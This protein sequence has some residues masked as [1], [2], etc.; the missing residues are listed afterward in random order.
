[1]RLMR[2]CLPGIRYDGVKQFLTCC[3]V[4]S[5]HQKLPVSFRATSDRC[6]FTTITRIPASP[7]DDAIVHIDDIDAN[8]TQ[9]SL[10]MT[11]FH[12]DEGFRPLFP[13]VLDCLTQTSRTLSFPVISNRFVLAKRCVSAQKFLIR[14]P[15]KRSRR[16]SFTSGSGRQR[17]ATGTRAERLSSY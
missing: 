10:G 5:R 11:A 1:M 16:C 12:L 9:T 8:A 2:C 4:I 15:A 13:L 17:H 3:S 6:P 7:F 14:V